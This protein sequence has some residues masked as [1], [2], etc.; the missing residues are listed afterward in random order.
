MLNISTGLAEHSVVF[1]ERLRRDLRDVDV[2]IGV[3][4]FPVWHRR[5]VGVITA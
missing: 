3:T 5:G 1:A 2:G 4:S